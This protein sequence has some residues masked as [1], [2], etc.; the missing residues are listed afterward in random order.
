[1]K[2]GVNM[3]SVM[4][5][6]CIMFLSGCGIFETEEESII[7]FG[8]RKNEMLK[9]DKISIGV[10]GNANPLSIKGELN[11]NAAI[12]SLAWESENYRT[13]NSG[14]VIIKFEIKTELNKLISKGEISIPL[15]KDWAWSVEISHSN[16]D[17]LIGCFGCVESK[18]FPILESEY[19]S[20]NADSI[21]IVYGGNSI[22]N[23]VI[24]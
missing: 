16:S 23:P 5:F 10:I 12:G 20:N 21:F 3:K 24:Y 2:D 9:N 8:V 14:S 1:M 18:S 7:K 11:N 13:A 4:I 15:K 22:S 17:P 19:I 6:I